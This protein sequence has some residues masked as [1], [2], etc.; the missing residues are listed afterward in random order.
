MVKRLAAVGIQLD[1]E[2][3]IGDYLSKV[4]KKRFARHVENYYNIPALQVQ[5]LHGVHAYLME[6][7]LTSIIVGMEE[8]DTTNVFGVTQVETSKKTPTPQNNEHP[9]TQNPDV[10]A[11]IQQHD[12]PRNWKNADRVPPDVW[13]RLTPMQRSAII[14]NRN[15]RRNGNSSRGRG[16]GGDRYGSG[17]RYPSYPPVHSMQQPYNNMRQVPHTQANSFNGFFG[18]VWE[19]DE[20]QP[21][22]ILGIVDDVYSN[23]TFILDTGAAHHVLNTCNNLTEMRNEKANIRVANGDS[24]DN[25]TVGTHPV[26]GD[27]IY[28]P[29]CPVNLISF[30]KLEKQGFRIEFKQG[31]FIIMREGLPNIEFKQSESTG[32]FTYEAAEII[33]NLHYVGNQYFT[34]KEIKRAILARKLHLLL[35]HPAPYRIKEL[36]NAGY[37]QTW[38]LSVNDV[39]NAEILYGKCF[40]C[41]AAKLTAPQIGPTRQ[42]SSTIGEHLHGDIV[43]VMGLPFLLVEDESTGYLSMVQLK[44]RKKETLLQ[45]ILSIIHTYKFYG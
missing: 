41:D 29:Q 35:M 45:S 13:E 32:M 39:D 43:F 36:L 44:D 17:G 15:Y 4:S 21:E 5:T 18:I 30:R 10:V 1:Q 28:M 26:W 40:A 27:C 24:Y 14:Q 9:K 23:N 22:D 25:V 33:T 11:A 8:E 20:I 6:K 42:K 34:E 31:V 38:G 37:F 3:M 7:A 12:T 16:R 2:T 19:E